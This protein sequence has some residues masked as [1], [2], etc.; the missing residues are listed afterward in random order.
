MKA[1]S[2]P[3]SNLKIIA[4]TLLLIGIIFVSVNFISP[5]TVLVQK[6]VEVPHQVSIPNE[7][8]LSSRPAFN[9]NDSGYQYFPAVKI[10]TGQTLELNWYSDIFL[11]VYIFSQEQFSNFQSIFPKTLA[12]KGITSDPAAWANKNGITYEAAAWA[13]KNGEVSYNVT[14]SGDYVAVITNAMYNGIA[15]AQIYYFNESL[16]SYTYQTHYTTQIQNVTQNDNL[17]LYMGSVFIILAI[18]IIFLSRRTPRNT[19]IEP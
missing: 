13:N 19:S 3:S 10:T 7:S 9:L 1:K 17:Y 8:S 18:L 15:F 16:I 12:E 2:I 5:H 11:G 14:E 6:S 4:I